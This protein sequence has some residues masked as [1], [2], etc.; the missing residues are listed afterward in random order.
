VPEEG[1]PGPESG[2]A[3]SNY[4]FAGVSAVTVKPGSVR[5]VAVSFNSEEPVD[6]AA[7]VWV[8]SDPSVAAVRGMGGKCAVM[9]KREGAA[10]VVA[11]HPDMPL[12]YAFRVVCAAD[13]A[14]EKKFRRTGGER[15]E[16]RLVGGWSNLELA[17]SR[18]E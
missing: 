17:E 10:V 15:T 12:P 7:Y 4:L 8:S 16:G 9:G 5:T 14:A 13:G 11:S 1:V 2:G 6:E 3:G 18:G